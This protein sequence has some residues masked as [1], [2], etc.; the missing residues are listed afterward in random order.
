MNTG[1]NR[2]STHKNRT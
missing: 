1:Y 2:R